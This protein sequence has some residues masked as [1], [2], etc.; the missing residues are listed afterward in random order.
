MTA[1]SRPEK[2][3]SHASQACVA[4]KNGRVDARIGIA[5]QC[6]AQMAGRAPN[7]PE[8]RPPEGAVLALS[9]SLQIVPDSTL[10]TCMRVTHGPSDTND[11]MMPKR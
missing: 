2:A 3:T 8:A 10:S 7:H 4:A 6:T 11:L 9:T 5:R 1:A